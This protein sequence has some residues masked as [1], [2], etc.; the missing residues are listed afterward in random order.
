MEDVVALVTEDVAV[1]PQ[2]VDVLEVVGIMSEDFLAMPV[3]LLVDLVLQQ[4]VVHAHHPA[5]K[6][7]LALLAASAQQLV[8]GP[9][10]M[11]LLLR[12][13]PTHAHIPGTSVQ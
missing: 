6:D 13:H 3:L 9:L 8:E 5:A 10:A 2:P 12:L 1:V 7:E 4:A 11:A